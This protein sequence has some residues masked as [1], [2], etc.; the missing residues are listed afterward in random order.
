MELV[1]YEEFIVFRDKVHNRIDLY[2]FTENLVKGCG[3]NVSS[4]FN[5]S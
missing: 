3:L 4:D 2:L 1:S 5:L